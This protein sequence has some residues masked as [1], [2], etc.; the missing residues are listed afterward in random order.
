MPDVIA[1]F[2][3]DTSDLD[4]KIKK[5]SQTLMQMESDCRKVG[6]AFIHL[7]QKEVDFIRS[8]GRMETGCKSAKG[9]LSQLTD[10]FTNM[11]AVYNRLSDEEKQDEGGK[12]LRASLEQLKER[13]KEGQKELNNINDQVKVN[14]SLLDQLSSK[15]GV[16][17]SQLIGWGTAIAAAKGA[18]NVMGDALM[19]NEST[20]D[21]WGRI[22]QS[23]ESVY[24][25]FLNALN[26]GDIGG[27]LSTIDT[28]IQAAREAYDTL[29]ELGTYNA[30]SQKEKA[31]NKAGYSEA[32]DN[33]KRNPTA[34]NKK[35]L[36]ESNR[37]VIA[38]LTTE[39]KKTDDAYRKALRQI[40][41]ERGLNKKQQDQFVNV[42]ANGSYG[43]FTKAKA[44]Y[45]TG[46]L[47]NAG[48]QYWNGNRVYD[49]RIQE[50]GKWRD[51][52]AQEKQNFTF[53]RALSQT[54]DEQIKNLQQ[55]GAQADALR[56]AAADQNRSFNRM[57]GNNGTRTTGGGGRS[58]GGRTTTTTPE[59]VA[60]SIAYLQKQ[61]QEAGKMINEAA[62]DEARIAAQKLYNEYEQKIKTLKDITKMEAEGTSMFAKIGGTDISKELESKR[63]GK[64]SIVQP[65]DL[66]TISGL[67]SEISVLK[68]MI[69][70]FPQFISDEDL[71]RFDELT[72]KL[73]N[74]KDNIPLTPAQQAAKAAEDNVKAWTSAANAIG[75]VG[76]ALASIDDPAAKVAGLI[77][78]AIATIAQTFAASLNGTFTPWDW[79][80]G[81]TAGTATM[82]STISAIKSATAGN[83]AN[84]GIIPGNSYSGDN[85]RMYGVNS[86]EVVLN[87]AQTANLATK[88]NDAHNEP[89]QTTAMVDGEKVLIAINAHLGATG[90]GELVVSR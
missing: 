33:Y 6:G 63:G 76:S 5:A 66:D 87:Q 54:N 4:T 47:L 61:M 72:A 16:S 15:F 89:R 18:L 8:M 44:G 71:T 27:F 69:E 19:N 30:F 48:A 86:G 73:Q 65:N 13:I 59:P 55:L 14:G 10:A 82:I 2:K 90:R 9:T 67:T 23:S 58:G 25:S 32:L 80:A 35:A 53:A 85:L 75:S 49:G 26:N 24:N 21:E 42:F 29:D 68:T 20:L 39:Q 37:K 38:D 83:Y 74:M 46:R 57:A 78:Q 34:A 84:G 22:T 45:S 52:S 62:T 11:R 40:A 70:E 1:R 56:Q 31:K 77:A 28:I 60:G 12:A 36:E 3:G 79:I 88:L 17:A 51:M 64:I 43:D 81:A 7:E 41:V 50:G